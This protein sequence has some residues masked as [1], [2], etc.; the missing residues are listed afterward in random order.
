MRV[1][2]FPPV[3]SE[4][5]GGC[6]T[7]DMG[8]V[9]GRLQ[10]EMELAGYTIVDGATLV[11]Q[12]RQRDSASADLRVFGERVALAHGVR[13]QGALFVDLPPALRRHVLQEAHANA[14]LRV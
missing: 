7:L 6:D 5:D 10:S 1:V 14:I 12:A 2:M 3:C 11:A 4:A 8:G 13:Q 9:A